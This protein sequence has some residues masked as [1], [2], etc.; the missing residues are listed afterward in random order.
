[1][2]YYNMAKLVEEIV[3][4]KLSKLVKD[5]SGSDNVLSDEQKALL[6]ATVPALVDEVLN[7]SAVIVELADLE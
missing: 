6:I 1:M 7:D 5:H 4:L 3:V 2:R